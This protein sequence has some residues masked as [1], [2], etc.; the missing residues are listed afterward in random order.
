MSSTN[1]LEKVCGD[2]H[3]L[4]LQHFAKSDVLKASEVS[5]E[6]NETISKS[7]KCM[8][9]IHLRFG[10]SNEAPEAIIESQRQ[11]SDLSVSVD[12]SSSALIF[13]QKFQLV[14]K[15][16]P[17]LK[18]LEIHNY[19]RFVYEPRNLQLPK[20]ESLVIRAKDPIVFANVTKLKK[21][22]LS[23]SNF[24]RA[25]IE[26]IEKQKKLE[27]L[28]LVGLRKDFF[29]FDPKAPKGIKRFECNIWHGLTDAAKLN[30]FMDSMCESLTRLTLFGPIFPANI[31]IIVN[32]MTKLKSLKL[33]RT[34][35]KDLNKAKLKTNF[36]ITELVIWK[37]YPE[38]QYLLLSLLNLK[39]LSILGWNGIDVADFEWIARNLM[40]L[41]KLWSS[42]FKP[43]RER[44]IE[45]YNEMKASE[46]GINMDIEIIDVLHG[47][48]V[49]DTVDREILLFA[50]QR[51]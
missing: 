35:M 15:F 23:F 31:E 42:R 20:L 40:K 18:K 14:E 13:Q 26:W 8:A 32:Q 37:L 12:S 47:F 16:S 5:P 6:W 43:S 51:C 41:K 27:E 36:N 21:L 25:T 17:F 3:E 50:D 1:P 28:N 4:M 30:N 10:L 7:L 11:Y 45:R 24:D 39:E 48:V 38:Y 22:S 44:I 49:G 29:E 34:V 33:S 9:K 2:L 46:E 19:S